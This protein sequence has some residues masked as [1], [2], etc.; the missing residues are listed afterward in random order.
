MKS[1]IML[2]TSIEVDDRTGN[3]LAVYFFIRPGKPAE[4]REYANCRAM[5]DYDRDGILLGIELLGPCEVSILDK[6]SR[7]QPKPV[8]NFLRKSI[9]VEMALT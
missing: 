4:T 3:V 1:N 6:I 8:K 2:R 7:N 5:A 9:P